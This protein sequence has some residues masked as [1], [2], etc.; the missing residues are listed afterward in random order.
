MASGIPQSLAEQR[1]FGHDVA[2]MKKAQVLVAV[3][4]G[5]VVDDGV[6]FEIGYMYALGKTCVGLQTDI[7]RALPTGNNPMLAQS[8]SMVFLD[9]DSLMDWVF[10]Y[11]SHIAF[12]IA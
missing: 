8:L 7:R 9:V 2:A 12:D 4:D 11:H 1:V 5:A 6:A 3:L 10:E